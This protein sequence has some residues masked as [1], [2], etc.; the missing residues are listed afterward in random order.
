MENNFLFGT[1]NFMSSN[2]DIEKKST[3]VLMSNITLDINTFQL[4]FNAKMF[5]LPSRQC[6]AI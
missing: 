4:D 2:F 6:H 1:F 3:V 5:Q